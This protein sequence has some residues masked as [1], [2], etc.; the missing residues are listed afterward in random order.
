MILPEGVKRLFILVSVGYWA[1]ALWWVDR[2]GLLINMRAAAVDA[3]EAADVSGGP[4]L[5]QLHDTFANAHDKLVAA[6]G[7]QPFFVLVIL[8][9][10]YIG[11]CA[12]LFSVLW[13]LDG[14]RQD[15][16]VSMSGRRHSS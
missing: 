13:L 2:V 9:A 7:S 14:F 15:R 12:L 6:T 16:P 8:F 5:E 4:P 3:D 1:I 10:T 11:T